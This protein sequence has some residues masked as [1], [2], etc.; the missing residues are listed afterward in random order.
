[1]AN[2]PVRKQ[3]NE[4]SRNLNVF[5]DLG[6]KIKRGLSQGFDRHGPSRNTMNPARKKRAQKWE[7]DQAA[8]KRKKGQG[9]R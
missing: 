8:K 7:R 3:L 9:R 4:L 1:M 6:G 2:L 5:D